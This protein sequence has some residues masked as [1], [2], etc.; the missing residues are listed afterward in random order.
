MDRKPAIRVWN[1]LRLRILVA[2]TLLS[3][4]C[5][6]AY[7]VASDFISKV[8]ND[9]LFNWY[10]LEN[11]REIVE[12]DLRPESDR[13]RYF[14]EGNDIDAY[15]LISEKFGM[16]EPFTGEGFKGMEALANTDNLGNGERLYEFT[17]LNK[18]LQVVKVP[19]DDKFQYV[20]YDIS[21][22][23][24]VLSE[25]SFI[26]DKN[27]KWLILPL[28]IFITAMGLL[29]GAIMSH[30]VMKPLI[31][32]AKTVGDT[33]PEHIPK[34]LSAQ[35]FPDEVGT[36]ARTIES[37]M[38]RIETYVEHERR[39]S[40]EVSH[41]LRTPVTSIHVSLE[42]LESMSLSPQQRRLVDRIERA[43]NEM[44]HLIQTFL[45]L[46]R[47][48]LDYDDVRT[49]T[50]YTFCEA[51]V[52]KHRHV[53]QG[54]SVNVDIQVDPSLTI[55]ICDYLFETV[56]SNLIRNAF[57]YTQTGSVLIQADS[58]CIKIVDTGCGIPFDQ[59][60]RISQPYNK[61]QP[62]GIGLGLSI[63]QRI[64]EKLDWEF[65]ISSDQSK[66]TVVT[67]VFDAKKHTG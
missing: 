62:E 22:F 7:G 10:A 49:I 30:R 20:I 53:L 45:L 8:V 11:A 66:G 39:F 43:N 51:L 26:S 37:L 54:K 29:I 16:N 61:L 32:L 24:S 1:S 47:D 38:V 42:L 18:G 4:I 25:D 36:V 44:S 59:L 65:T 67:V 48:T 2:F 40:R 46:G 21:D 55:T 23:T 17:F 12:Q 19:R 31:R 13:L 50:L 28:T 35:F 14:V 57:Q 64:V 27:T 9:Q 56:V 5:A 63:V 6:I 58:S 33:D 34:E 60:D 52:E 15:N 41:E 3:F